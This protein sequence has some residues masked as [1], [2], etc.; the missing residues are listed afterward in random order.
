MIL[1]PF[2]NYLK[3]IKNPAYFTK[4]IDMIVK[5][6]DTIPQQY[7][8]MLDP[9]FN[10]MILNGI[11]ASKQSK[12]MTEQADYVKSKLPVKAKVPASADVPA[13]TLQKY[14]GKY[15]L[16]GSEATVALKDGKTLNLNIPGQPEMELILASKSKFTIKYM[17][18]YSVEF[19]GNDKGEVTEFVFVS[20]G[21]EVK[22][23]RKK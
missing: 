13:E 6:R 23:P 9:Y 5:F 21:G 12:G 15:D 10:G 20:P 4:G 14:T 17:E 19:T 2:A 8:Q 7:H 11:A 18:G 22:A 1:Q 3:R 16:N